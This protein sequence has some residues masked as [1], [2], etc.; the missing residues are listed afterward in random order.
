M[1]SCTVKQEYEKQRPRL[2]IRP[3]RRRET[4]SKDA[5]YVTLSPTRLITALTRSR[6]GHNIIR[7]VKQRSLLAPSC[8]VDGVTL[9]TRDDILL[10]PGLPLLGLCRSCGWFAGA[11]TMSATSLNI[12]HKS[13]LLRVDLRRVTRAAIAIFNTA[14]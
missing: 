7:I 1:L 10:V 13:D 14:F 9:Q 12:R 8:K 2:H 5:P 11:T 3:E 4:D 6:S